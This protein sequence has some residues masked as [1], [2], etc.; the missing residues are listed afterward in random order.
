MSPSTAAV[1]RRSGVCRF[2]TWK[3]FRVQRHDK[4]DTLC[5]EVIMP[6]TVHD[7]RSN[8]MELQTIAHQQDAFRIPPAAPN[9]ELSKYIEDQNSDKNVMLV[10][11]FP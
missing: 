11:L 9:R 5:V 6:Q 7:V 10:S 8:V 4:G 1:T 2:S 3:G